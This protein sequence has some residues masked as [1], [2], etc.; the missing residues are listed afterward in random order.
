MSVLLGLLHWIENPYIVAF[1]S[2]V[3]VSRNCSSK[4]VDTRGVA[5]LRVLPTVHCARS[6]LLIP[7]FLRRALAC[8]D[9]SLRCGENYHF[10]SHD[11]GMD[12][13]ISILLRSSHSSS[14]AHA[15]K[16]QAQGGNGKG[17][18]H[19]GKRESYDVDA[20]DPTSAAMDRIYIH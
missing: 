6:K 11:A 20:S 19:S 15:H 14:L 4:A 9:T 16:S 1:E 18:D 7:L 10:H 8:A 3:E 2:V 13:A 12:S 17:V 5:K